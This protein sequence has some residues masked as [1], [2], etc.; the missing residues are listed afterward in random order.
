MAVRPDRP[1]LVRV[2]SSSADAP[3]MRQP[4]DVLLLAAA[5]F[6]LGFLT[7][8]APGPSGADRAF[9]TFLAWLEPVFGW[10]WS[11][12][13]A[14]LAVW[15]VCVVLL[16]ALSRGRRRLLIDQATASVVAFAAAIGVGALAGTD[17]SVAVDALGASGPPVVY[18]ATRVAVLT[19]VLVTAS[20]HLARPWR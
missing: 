6:A 12:A 16:A 4:T 18:L 2:W 3:R 14:L 1:G 20:P 10:L 5:I 15:A 13:Y 11:I 9:N 17:A 8:A 7:L 19:A